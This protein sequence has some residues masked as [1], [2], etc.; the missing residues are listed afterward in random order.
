MF[1]TTVESLQPATLMKQ[2]K[3]S[4][5]CVTLPE[6]LLGMVS[7]VLRRTHVRRTQLSAI[8]M[9]IVWIQEECNMVAGVRTIS[10]V[11]V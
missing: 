3:G 8:P 9:Q 4:D 11:M 1:L 5:V 10:S 7:A 2:K 6:G